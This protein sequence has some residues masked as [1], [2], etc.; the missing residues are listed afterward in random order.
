MVE[1][2]R[3]NI[4]LLKRPLADFICILQSSENGRL[5][6]RYID[7]PPDDD[8]IVVGEEDVIKLAEQQEKEL[9]KDFLSAIDKQRQV[10]FTPK[11]ERKVGVSLKDV[12]DAT[13]ESILKI[14]SEDNNE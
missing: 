8:G 13:Y 7:S 5:R 3:G 6:V 11:K 1:F 10:I 14:L 4:L 12:D 9:P 2:Y